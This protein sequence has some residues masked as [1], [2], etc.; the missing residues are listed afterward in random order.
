VPLLYALILG[1]VE[2]LTEF[3]PVSSTGHLIVAGRA[4][5]L[6]KTDA[7]DAF[8][9]VIQGGAIL[10]VA[11]HYRLLLA[12]H[13]K[14]L[15]RRRPESV[16]LFVSMLVAFLPIAVLGKLFGHAIKDRLFAPLPVAVA[17][18]AG[19]A[20]ML[21]VERVRKGHG[22][23]G[24]ENVTP[25]RALAIGAGQCLALLPGTSR[26]MA[27]IVAGQLTGLSTRTAAEFSFLVG[28]PTLGAAT[29]YEGY[30]SRHVLAD[31]IGAASIAVGLVVSFLVAWGVIASFLRYLTKR[32][33]EP[34]GV[35]RVVFGGLVLWM[36]LR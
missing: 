30:K 27:S 20:L 5:G 1:V 19:G 33:L 2:G 24:L 7:V 36:A 3:L 6:A 16:R 18:I 32:G 21:V 34:F 22:A 13:V 17:L 8:E 23:D 4:L 29:L 25:M 15:A 9:I 14:G 35:Y 10:A 26:S 31:E 12:T 11:V 28:L